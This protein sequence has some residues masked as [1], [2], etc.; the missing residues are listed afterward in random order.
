MKLPHFIRISIIACLLI[1]L[2]FLCGCTGTAP[3]SPGVAKPP[4]SATVIDSP[5]TTPTPP[6]APS[7]PLS[8]SPASKITILS[9][10]D[11][12]TVNYRT[13]IKGTS[14]GIYKTGQNFYIVILPQDP[15]DTY[16]VQP[17]VTMQEN[18]DWSLLAY[19]GED[20]SSKFT[21][22]KF[23]VYAVVSPAKLTIG[24]TKNPPGGVKQTIELTRA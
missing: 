16:W 6:T 5:Q 23:T 1:G 7:A 14:T 15:G 4:T 12:T 9:P 18:G 19:F 8:P 10:Q 17:E 13:T 11:S 21:G 22:K 20:A 24:D 2:I 3:A